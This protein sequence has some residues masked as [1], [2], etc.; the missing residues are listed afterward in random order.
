MTYDSNEDSGA[1]RTRSYTSSEQTY[2]KHIDIRRMATAM[3]G[4]LGGAALQAQICLRH[5][6]RQGIHLTSKISK[7]EQRVIAS[8][9]V[10]HLI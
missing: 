8:L 3:D 1:M 10:P 2:N 9:F 6:E 7:V 5:R 4:A